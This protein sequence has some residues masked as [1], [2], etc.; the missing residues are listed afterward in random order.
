MK[1]DNKIP[2]GEAAYTELGL[3]LA[4]TDPVGGDTGG[5]LAEGGAETEGT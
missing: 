5:A 1:F 2:A 3:G 4:E